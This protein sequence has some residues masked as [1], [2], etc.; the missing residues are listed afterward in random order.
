MSKDVKPDPEKTIA[1]GASA[2]GKPGAAHG[3][4]EA[5]GLGRAG[6]DKPLGGA[7]KSPDKA[8]L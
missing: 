3:Q 7:G 6:N 8:K 1:A 5:E 4:D 2:A